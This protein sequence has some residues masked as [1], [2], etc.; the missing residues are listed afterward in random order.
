MTTSKTKKLYRS[1]SDRM[2]AGVAGGLA[3][4][5]EI[6][7]TIVRLI[8]ITLS[9]IGGSGLLAYFILWVVVPSKSSAKKTDTDTVSENINEIKEKAKSLTKHTSVKN[10][11]SP[12][13]VGLIFIIIG[14]YFLLNNFG[15][16]LRFIRTDLLWPVIFI[17]LG[18]SIITRKK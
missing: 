16:N 13:L 11:S 7:S 14:I 4:Y 6:D 10:S 9:L 2:L 12:S 15:I 18:L 3:D 8:F 5:F 17:I 1:E